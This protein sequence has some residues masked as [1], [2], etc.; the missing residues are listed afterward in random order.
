MLINPFIVTPVIVLLV[1]IIPMKSKIG[2]FIN[3]T[4]IGLYVL[5]LSVKVSWPEYGSYY[6]K[7]FY[8]TVYFVFAFILMRKTKNLPKKIKQSKIKQAIRLLQLFLAATLFIVLTYHYY[9][10][11]KVDSP[12]INLTFPLKGGKYFIGDGGSKIINSHQSF[13]ERNSIDIVKLNN[14]GR[15][16]K[17]G[18]VSF[19][20]SLSDYNIYRDTI[21]SPCEGTIINYYDS[22]SDHDAGFKSNF[23]EK[24]SNFIEILT[25][26]SNIVILLHLANN[27]SF[28]RIGDTVS[29]GTPIAL[30]GN[31]GIS[32]FP[33]LHI[34]A[35][36]TNDETQSES[37]H[38][39]FNGKNL[40]TNDVFNH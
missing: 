2:F 17:S 34:H 26:D 10:A 14:L 3:A 11:F 24:K 31:S 21:Y 40:V 7:F 13:L 6:L 16:W 20:K 8:V 5:L 12:T 28:L 15:I 32:K 33:H 9:G 30:V 35:F 19:P 37:M 25:P 29:E 1:F 38:I 4:I 23:L 27:S 22:F 39:L 36:R 18:S